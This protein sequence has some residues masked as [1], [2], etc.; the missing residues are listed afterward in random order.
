V[1]KSLQAG[2]QN[3]ILVATAVSVAIWQI[4]SNAEITSH[5]AAITQ[6]GQLKNLSNVAVSSQISHILNPF[7]V[8]EKQRW[9]FQWYMNSLILPGFSH[10]DA[11][12]QHHTTICLET[13]SS[14][15]AQQPA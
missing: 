4:P 10:F 8:V 12:G 14:E 11:T 2:I 3:A 13:N 6:F 1:T 9:E 5:I 7:W 15:N